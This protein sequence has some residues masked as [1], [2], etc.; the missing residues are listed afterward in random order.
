MSMMMMEMRKTVGGRIITGREEGLRLEMVVD[1]LYPNAF[2][3]YELDFLLFWRALGV[4]V[5]KS[6][7]VFHV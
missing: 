5:M 2:T 4:H 7:A 6:C 1:N 3:F